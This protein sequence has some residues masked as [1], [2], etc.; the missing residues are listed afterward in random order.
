[1]SLESVCINV[2]FTLSPFYYQVQRNNGDDDDEG[3]AVTYA[4][5]KVPSSSFGDSHCL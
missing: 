5:V 2:R 4:T 3:D 1:M